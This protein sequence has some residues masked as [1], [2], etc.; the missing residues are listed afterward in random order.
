MNREDIVV[1][2]C[3]GKCCECF[4]LPLS[5][6]EIQQL[7]KITNKEFENGD[8]LSGIRSENGKFWYPPNKE[9]INKIAEMLIPLGKTNIDPQ[10]GNNE[11]TFKEVYELKLK[12]TEQPNIKNEDGTWNLEALGYFFSSDENNELYSNIFTCKHFDKEN[13]IC[14]NYDNRP[15]LCSSF[16]ITNQCRYKDCKCMPI[17]NKQS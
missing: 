9:E 14:L 17:I 5:Y 13:K 1:N 8:L 4:T 3:V 10:E 16:G 15:T 11:K 7:N 12:V 6:D 2:G